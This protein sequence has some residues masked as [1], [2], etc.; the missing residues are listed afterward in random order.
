MV[1]RA[2]SVR[3]GAPSSG[4]PSLPAPSALEGPP[5]GGAMKAR[6]MREQGQAN[7]AA[8]E[9]HK[10]SEALERRRMAMNSVK[11][12]A[13]IGVQKV[14]GVVVDGRGP[15]NIN[16]PRGSESNGSNGIG[17][18]GVQVKPGRQRGSSANSSDEEPDAFFERRCGA[19]SQMDIRFLKALICNCI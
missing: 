1:S 11:P 6:R 16:T 10:K 13:E 4:D 8:A 9:A 19:E 17:V 7:L 5:V 15:L 18:V 12:P 3:S 2:P 14:G